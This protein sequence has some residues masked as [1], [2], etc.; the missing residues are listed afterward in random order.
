V[1]ER[2]PAGALIAQPLGMAPEPARPEALSAAGGIP[3]P[4]TNANMSPPRPHMC[5]ATT[6]ITAAAVTAASAALPSRSSADRPA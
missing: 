6:A 5:G 3:G 2:H 4:A 1:L